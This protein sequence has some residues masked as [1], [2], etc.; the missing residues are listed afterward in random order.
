MNF[1]NKYYKYKLKY[2]KL[3]QIGGYNHIRSVKSLFD[4]NNFIIHN[5]NKV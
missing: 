5:Y 2:L 4:K 3:K 1:K